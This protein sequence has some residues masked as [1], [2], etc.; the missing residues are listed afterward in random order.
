[1]T[2]K[3]KV[4]TSSIASSVVALFATKASAAPVGGIGTDLP[5]TPLEQYITIGIN[6]AIW[7]AGL[8]SVVFII[9]GGFQ[10]ITAGASKDGT[11]KAKTTLTYAIIGLIV[12]ALALVIRNFV[13]GRF[14]LQGVVGT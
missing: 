4:V 2:R 1:M 8:L 10:Y 7:A 9:I 11:T 6:T 3:I 14:Q 13:L 5:N 12:V